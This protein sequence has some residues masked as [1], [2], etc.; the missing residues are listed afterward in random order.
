MAKPTNPNI[1]IPQGFANEGQKTD[2]LEEKIQKGFDPVDP[3]V[4][5]GD[6]LNKFI[7]DTYKGL[8]YTIDGV[9][10]L[11]KGVVLY[12]SSETYSSTSIVF[13]IAD[14]E[15][16]AY[17]SLTD[18][19]LGNPLTD[20]TKWKKVNLGSGG[21][22]LELC[23]IGM[24]LYIDETKGLRRRLNGQVVAINANTQAFLNRLK[25][26][27]ALYPSLSVTET[28]WQAAKTASAYGQVG[29]FVIDEEAG[30]VRLPAVVNVQGALDLQNLGLTVEAGLPD[31]THTVAINL[32][33][34]STAAGWVGVCDGDNG[35]LNGAV[36]T[37]SGASASNAIYGNSDTVQPEAVQY[38]YFIQI[39]TGQE[40][41]NNI[42]NELELCNPFVL[43]EPKYSESLL[44]NESWLRS[45]GQWN[46]KA[47]YVSVYEALQVEYNSEIDAGSTVTLPS[48]GAYTKRGLPVKLSTE[49]YTDYDH[50][51][52]TSEETFRLA[53]KTMFKP[54]KNGTVPVVGTGIALGVTNG[55]S[56]GGMR[57]YLLDNAHHTTFN[58]VAYGT[59]VY[60]NSEPGTTILGTLGVTS[61][62]EKSGLVADL[63]DITGLYLYFYAGAVSQNAGIVNAGR[64]EEAL[65]DKL[66]S[67]HSN[68]T[69]PYLVEA[70]LNGKSG[71][72]VWS[73]GLIEQWGM[74]MTVNGVADVSLLKSYSNTD[75]SILTTAR[76]GNGQ[77]SNWNVNTDEDGLKTVSAFRARA[78]YGN[79]AVTGYASFWWC[80]RGY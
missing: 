44:Y 32:M 37:S 16:S 70:Y 25:Q 63:T 3:D 40:I 7:D 60:G 10:D 11:Y 76:G 24:S 15:I 59:A 79:S 14:D 6:N 65:V 43:L 33:D 42:V 30:T 9:N 61:D 8:N 26:I 55:T 52:N 20:E 23:D 58:D 21:G 51:L 31:H 77:F 18:D 50:V 17:K 67:D 54:V 5:A 35:I 57:S 13:S 12:D 66:N 53:L 47:L 34:D 78:A 39:A 22:G 68:D 75:Y 73:N 1:S 74:G 36:Y 38:P 56:F 4:L 72:N 46:A 69:K 28:A 80:T 62:P 29:K 48:G 45:N 27:V 2:F 49:E 41:E 19:N 64:V 71:Y